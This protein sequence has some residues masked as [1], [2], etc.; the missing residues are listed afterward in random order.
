MMKVFGWQRHK[1]TKIESHF[2]FQIVIF[3]I[4]SFHIVKVKSQ[5]LASKTSKWH[6][7]R[8]IRLFSFFH[9]QK[10]SNFTQF[11]VR[12]KHSKGSR[13]RSHT[14]E[15]PFFEII[16]LLSIKKMNQGTQS[17]II[18]KQRSYCPFIMLPNGARRT[19]PELTKRSKRGFITFFNLMAHAG[20]LKSKFLI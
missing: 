9:S 20:E 10:K 2:S 12:I 3:L 13:S 5:V 19:L 6:N 8:R 17:T 16:R 4:I 18:I 15:N 14:H 7:W 11:C 1:K